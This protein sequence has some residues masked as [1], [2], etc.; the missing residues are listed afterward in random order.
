MPTVDQLV[1]SNSLLAGGDM[2]F[3]TP[4]KN[5]FNPRN[6]IVSVYP[7]WA[8]QSGQLLVNASSPLYH[9][10]TQVSHPSITLQHL[11]KIGGPVNGVFRQILHLKASLIKC[12]RAIGIGLC[13]SSSFRSWTAATI[14]LFWSNHLSFHQVCW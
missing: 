8:L 12:C 3:A 6:I 14:S 4:D 10:L 13:L 1:F 2:T 9:W 11:L 7:R 5:S